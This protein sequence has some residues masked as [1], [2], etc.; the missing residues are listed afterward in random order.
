MPIY[1]IPR[2]IKIQLII[3]IT[4]KL[5]QFLIT[6][7]RAWPQFSLMDDDPMMPPTD[8]SPFLGQGDLVECS[9]SPFFM[10][11]FYVIAFYTSSRPTTLVNP[12]M[13]A[14]G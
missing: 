9:L 5:P 8:H 13:T 14:M 12:C 1:S 7:T 11:P 6:D 10:S 2:R 3:W 4:P